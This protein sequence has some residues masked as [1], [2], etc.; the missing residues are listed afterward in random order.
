IFHFTN[1]IILTSCT[2]CF[3]F[4]PL[5]GIVATNFSVVSGNLATKW[6]HSPK[7]LLG[8]IS[9]FL[10]ISVAIFC[11]GIHFADHPVLSCAGLFTIVGIFDDIYT[12]TPGKKLALQFFAAIISAK[13]FLLAPFSPW[14]AVEVFWIVL[15]VNAFNL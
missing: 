8:G 2:F 4:A 6:S 11:S 9:M 13:F 3:V 15:F 12:L 10:A 5:V 1:N 7:P 14:F